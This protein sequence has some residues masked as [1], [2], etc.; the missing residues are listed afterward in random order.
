MI[1]S[2]IIGLVLGATAIIFA[3]QNITTV[4]VVFLAW[5][6]QGSLALILVLAV[7]S[8]ILICS[9]LSLPDVIRKRFQ[10]SRLKDD[11]DKL[12]DSLVRKDIEVESEKSKLDANNAYIDGLREGS[13]DLTQASL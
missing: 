12:K 7:V 10:I 9:F 2:L 8:G 6:F 4:S 1:I 11:N 3:A 5:Q 13:E